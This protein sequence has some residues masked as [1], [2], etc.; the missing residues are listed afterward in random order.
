MSN[1]NQFQNIYNPAVVLVAG[2][3]FRKYFNIDELETVSSFAQWHLDLVRED[4]T[5]AYSDIGILQKDTLSGGFRFWTEFIV[6]EGLTPGCYRFAIQDDFYSQLRYLSNRV[7]VSTGTDYTKIVRFRNATNI[8]NYN[9]EGLPSLYNQFRLKLHQRHLTPQTKATGY[10]LING[11]FNPVRYTQGPTAE[12][13]TLWYDKEDHKA[14]N[15]ITLHSDLSI[16]SDNN[17]E[18]I[19]YVRGDQDYSI[20]WQDNYPLAEGTIRMQRN[21]EYSNNKLL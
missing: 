10:E 8:L 17:A 4:F 2:D 21:D 19:S 9:Y 12:F 13:I 20:D 6:P 5:V 7:E 11:S 15:S 3:T 16:E 14:F 1:F 18:M